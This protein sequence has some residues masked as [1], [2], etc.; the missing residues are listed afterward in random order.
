MYYWVEEQ[1]NTLRPPPPEQM[2][3]YLCGDIYIVFVVPQ[4]PV[5]FCMVFL[6]KMFKQGSQMA[7]CR[8]AEIAYLI[9]ISGLMTLFE[10]CQ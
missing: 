6:Q 5:V 3:L 4:P 2:A 9:S 8:A 10:K 1:P 7:L